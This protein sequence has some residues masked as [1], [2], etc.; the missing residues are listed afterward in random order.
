MGKPKGHIPVRTCASCGARQNKQDLVRF[1]LD[2]QDR[3]I[4]D[5]AFRMEGR[6]AYSC[7]RKECMERL[8]NSRH[9]AFR[10]LSKRVSRRVSPGSKNIGG[11][12][13]KSQ[14]L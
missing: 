2:E 4:L 1:V 13:G 11:F 6:G 9:K 14:G 10:R 8:E 12:N 3:L 5:Q 7:K